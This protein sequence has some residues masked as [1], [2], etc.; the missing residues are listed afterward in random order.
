M[1]ISYFNESTVVVVVFFSL[2]LLSSQPEVPFIL[3]GRGKPIQFTFDIDLWWLIIP[4][5]NISH[6]VYL[7]ESQALVHPKYRIVTH[8]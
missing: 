6:F 5:V 8:R 3:I 7:F 2:S 4:Y 1:N